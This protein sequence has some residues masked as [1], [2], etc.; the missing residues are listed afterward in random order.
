ASVAGDP[1]QWV[2]YNTFKILGDYTSASGEIESGNLITFA[3]AEWEVIRNG[4]DNEGRS[5]V[6]SESSISFFRNSSSIPGLPENPLDNWAVTRP[7]TDS[8]YLR[9]DRGTI[10]KAISALPREE[11]G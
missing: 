7:F 6:L 11:Y 2:F 5:V 10:I 1:V 4:I 8:V 3:D 9:G